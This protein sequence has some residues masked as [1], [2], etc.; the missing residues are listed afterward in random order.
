MLKKC[1]CLLFLMLLFPLQAK[2]DCDYKRQADLSKIASNVQIS[3]S[4][5]ID[6]NHEPQFFVNVTNLTDDVYIID[7]YDNVLRGSGEKEIKYSRGSNIRFVFYS[8]DPNCLDEKITTRYLKIPYFNQYYNTEECKKYPNFKYC[9][10][11]NYETI[12]EEQYKEELAKYTKKEDNSQIRNVN[13]KDEFNY[14]YI[15]YGAGILTIVFLVILIIKR[16]RKKRLI[17]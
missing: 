14:I 4:Y 16:L 5:L 1:F 9:K 10:L 11:W 12:G 8:N 17:N 2:A 7:D 15:I 6:E 13:Q 3:Y